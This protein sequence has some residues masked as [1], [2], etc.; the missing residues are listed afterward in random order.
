MKIAELFAELGFNINEKDQ[1]TVRDFV[2][3]LGDL[4]LS[5]VVA[6]LGMGTAA[7]ALVDLTE[8]MAKYATGLTMYNVLTGV[9]VEETQAWAEAVE[10]VGGSADDA[11]GAIM[12]IQQYMTRL[13]LGLE[14]GNLALSMFN[15]TANDSW[16][17]IL[18]KV[19]KALHEHATPA[20]KTFLAQ[21][22]G[23]NAA[24]QTFLATTNNL[25]QDL[26][27]SPVLS[28]GEVKDLTKS[29]SELTL[30]MQEFK[31]LGGDIAATIGPPL[32]GIVEVLRFVVELLE[33]VV[34]FSRI[35][36]KTWSS[37]GGVA[38]G[39][40]ENALGI[41]PA[42]SVTA[43]AGIGT[44]TNHVTF[45]INGSNDPN[46]VQKINDQLSKWLHD[47]THQLD[48]GNR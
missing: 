27:K 43:G 9:S 13:K 38:L 11:K 4:N 37:L 29:W 18:H 47:V 34:V 19:S 12:G 17:V 7:A 35:W 32:R 45:H 42:A 23:I 14:D 22:L 25:D 31:K 5:S 15:I 6:A 48:S 46:L 2:G 10:R 1:H 3:M 44:Q 16:D 20:M 30:T 21:Q 39:G 28:T 33:A 26:A 36:I 24:M 8:K 41:H 40:I